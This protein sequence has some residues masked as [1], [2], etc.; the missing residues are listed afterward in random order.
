MQRDNNDVYRFETNIG[1]EE[2]PIVLKHKFDYALYMKYMRIK[3]NGE[4]KDRSIKD[5]PGIGQHFVYNDKLCVI[6]KV[7]LHWHFGYYEHVVYRVFGTLSHGTI[8]LKNISSVDKS[9][10]ESAE[11][12]S[13]C[14]K[15][16]DE[17]VPIEQIN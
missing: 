17:D 7:S 9:I 8:I 15:V 3:T 4:Y 5:H 11:E 10:I 13:K 2:V 14:V 16:N 6:E 12:Y 1:T